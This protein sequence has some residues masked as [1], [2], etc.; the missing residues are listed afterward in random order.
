MG[1]GGIHPIQLVI[2]L[3]LALL[4]FGGRGRITSIMGDL[5][6]GVKSFRDGLKDSKEDAPSATE[7]PKPLDDE[8]TINITPDKDK[9]DV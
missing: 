5:A 8:G 4:F 9:S 2:V 3:V 7:A 6:N 1:L